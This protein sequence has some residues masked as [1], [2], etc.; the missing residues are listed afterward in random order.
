MPD[1]TDQS[2]QPLSTQALEQ[3]VAQLEQKVAQLEGGLDG[4]VNGLID[5]AFG[6]LNFTGQGCQVSGGGKTWTIIVQQF[7]G[8]TVNGTFACDVSPPV[9][10][11]TL[12]LT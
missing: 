7:T 11:G 4:R 3:R 12:T 2:S 8:G 1:R 6:T 10:N 5:A 9:F